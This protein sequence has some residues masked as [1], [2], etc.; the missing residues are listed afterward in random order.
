MLKG[1]SCC[2]KENFNLSQVTAEV[3]K[4]IFQ[5]SFVKCGIAWL[6]VSLFKL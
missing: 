2:P 5:I 4:S 1:F 3:F 6:S